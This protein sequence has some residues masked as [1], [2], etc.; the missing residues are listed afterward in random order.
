MDNQLKQ[1]FGSDLQNPE[2]DKHYSESLL[3]SGSWIQAVGAVLSALE[4]SKIKK[5]NN[6]LL[7][8]FCVGHADF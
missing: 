2:G 6:R 3:F 1:T 7:A 8:I 4:G 5:L